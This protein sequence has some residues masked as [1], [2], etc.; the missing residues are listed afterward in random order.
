MELKKTNQKRSKNRNAKHNT[1]IG[2]SQWAE[3]IYSVKQNSQ[4]CSKS[5]LGTQ[6]RSAST[7][8]KTFA[9]ILVSTQT[10]ERKDMKPL[11]SHSSKYRDSV[12]TGLHSQ[13]G[14]KSQESQKFKICLGIRYF[15]AMQPVCIHVCSKGNSRIRGFLQTNLR[16]YATVCR[17]KRV[18]KG[19]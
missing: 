17:K 13:K 7:R 1:K 11:P 4:E 19:K 15:T 12:E 3:A 6:S 9:K 5:D 14:P 2:A 18:W 16:V 8:N 10:K